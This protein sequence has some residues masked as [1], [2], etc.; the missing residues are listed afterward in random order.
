MERDM[1]ENAAEVWGKEKLLFPEMVYLGDTEEVQMYE[2][3]ESDIARGSLG[4]GCI[5][6]SRFDL[7]CSPKYL[8]S[9]TEDLLPIAGEFPIRNE[10]A[11]SG[12]LDPLGLFYP[13]VVLPHFIVCNSNLLKPNTMPRNLAD[14]LDPCWEGKIYMGSTELPSAKSFLF[15]MWYKFG[16][17]GLET[18]V[19]NWR[20]LSAPSACRHGLMKDRFP[21]GLLPGIFTNPGPG[22]K[23]LPIWPSEGAPVLPSYAAVKRS[24]YEQDILEFLRIS[25]A[26]NEFLRFYTEKGLAYP[27]NPAVNPPEELEDRTDF[28]FPAWEWIVEQDMEYF[29]DA[30]KRVPPG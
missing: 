15:A 3:L 29:E 22:D 1:M 10:V 2:Q 26:S 11:A 28:F 25:A 23:L 13:L 18:C 9:F 17:D 20:Q 12:V 6:S 21:V 8:Q 14:L 27:S 24:E 7:F 30:C 19:R 5:V 16:N 4:F